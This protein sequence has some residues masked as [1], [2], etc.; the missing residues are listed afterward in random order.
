MRFTGKRLISPLDLPEF[1]RYRSISTFV[2]MNR[3]FLL[4]ITVV[5]LTIST[6]VPAQGA[7]SGLIVTFDNIPQRVRRDNPDLAAARLRIQEA[8]ARMQQAGHR[9]N[10]LLEGGFARNGTRE[11][12]VEIS[13]S[14]RLSL[15][16]I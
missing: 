13:L 12:S 5:T 9:S 10:P 3:L 6:P 8:I 11:G 2:V 1:L 15:I 4:S 16:H 14:Q 7:S